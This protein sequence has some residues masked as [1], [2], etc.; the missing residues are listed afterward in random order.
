M[1]KVERDWKT[2]NEQLVRRGELLLDLDFVE[3]WEKELEEMN[4]GKRGKPFA[5][6]E[7][8]IRFLAFPRYFFRLPFRQEEGFVAALAKFVPG[9]EAP[10][11]STI[12][13]RINSLPLEFKRSLRELGDDV[14]V[15]IDASGIKVTNRGEWIRE[16]WD[17]TPRR[18]YLKIHLAV[19][20]K[21]KQILAMEVT[22]ERTGDIKMFRPLVEQASG[23]ARVKLVLADSAYDSRENFNFLEAKGIGPGIKVR[24]GA[25][26]KAR[27]SWAR[28]RTAREFLEDEKRWKKRVGYGRR[29]AVEGTFSSLKRTFGEFVMAQKF[30]NMAKEMLLKAFCYNLL[31]NLS[32]G[33]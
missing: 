7:S 32:V 11:Y 33:R 30:E 31:M 12:C 25:S 14:V 28:R 2:Y 22:D 19:D 23:R 5:Y 27:G 18:G 9:L 13:R 24:R 29:W 4:R 1:S 3:N 20:T 16:Q 17:R 8:L 6:P 15:A 10:N 21:T 26:G